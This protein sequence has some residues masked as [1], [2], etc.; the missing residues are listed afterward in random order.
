MHCTCKWWSK[1]SFRG[2]NTTENFDHLAALDQHKGYK[3]PPLTGTICLFWIS[4]QILWFIAV[5]TNSHT[6]PYILNT[7]TP[8][9]KPGL[10]VVVFTDCYPEKGLLKPI[11]WDSKL[12]LLPSLVHVQI[13]SQHI[14]KEHKRNY[15]TEVRYYTS[16]DAVLMYKLTWASFML[17]KYC[18]Q[19]K[20]HCI[21]Y[22]SMDRIMW[23]FKSALVPIFTMIVFKFRRKYFHVF[24]SPGIQWNIWLL[25]VQSLY[26]LQIK[27]RNE[28]DHRSCKENPEKKIP[29]YNCLCTSH[30]K[31]HLICICF[32]TAKIT[33]TST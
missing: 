25:E 16:L 29:L 30:L 9:P 22:M 12:S 15:S 19:Q 27:N 18:A 28:H 26:S 4:W 17:L 6:F 11:E 1:C 23:N 5:I 20:D 32:A 8:P 14:I 7:P 21:I 3:G 31:P 10:P 24:C 13:L 33:F 2:G